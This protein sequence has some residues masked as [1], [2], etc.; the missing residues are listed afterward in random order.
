MADL[1]EIIVVTNVP[2]RIQRSTQLRKIT[3]GIAE[4]TPQKPLFEEHHS[5]RSGT[6]EHIQ[7]QF[8]LSSSISSDFCTPLPQN[9]NQQEVWCQELGTR[10]KDQQ[11]DSVVNA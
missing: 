2:W 8:K 11:I 5:M 1:G 7:E 9:L 4:K 10:V 6:E 3:Y